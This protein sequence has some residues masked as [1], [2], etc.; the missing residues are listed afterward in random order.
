M[1]AFM[2][3]IATNKAHEP[4]KLSEGLT[5]SPLKH[6]RKDIHLRFDISASSRYATTKAMYPS[7]RPVP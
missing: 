2:D 3:K 7:N 5:F 1:K 6:K 4:D